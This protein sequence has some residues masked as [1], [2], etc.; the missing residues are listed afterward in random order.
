MTMFTIPTADSFPTSLLVAGDGMVW[1]SEGM[2]N[3]L[4]RLDP[5]SGTI[6]EYAVPRAADAWPTGLAVDA[7]GRLWLAENLA[8]Q[9]A[10]FD[11]AM[12]RRRTSGAGDD[13]SGRER[14]IERNVLPEDYSLTVPLRREHL[15]SWLVSGRSG[16]RNLE[17]LVAKG[18]DIVPVYRPKA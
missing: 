15:R 12:G 5:G 17:H 18:G 10:M 14:R 8:D 2:G 11:P 16:Q 9:I 7:A 13:A 3:R 6:V 1:F 4:G